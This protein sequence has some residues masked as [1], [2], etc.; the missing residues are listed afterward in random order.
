MASDSAATFGTGGI[1]TIGQQ[2]VRKLHRLNEN[3]LFSS[4]GA[5]GVSQLIADKLKSEWDKKTF[6]GIQSPDELMDKIGKTIV[7]L[8]GPYLQSATW[9]QPLGADT[10]SSLC[11]SLVAMP[12]ASTP[13]LF[14][15]DFNGA[16]ERATLQLPFIALGSGQPIADPFL[17]FLKRLLWVTTEPTVAEGKLAAVWTIDHVR[18]TTPGGVG[19]GIQ[20]GVLSGKAGKAPTVELLADGDIEEHLQKVSTTERAL[21][22]ELCGR[23]DTPPQL[24]S[25]EQQAQT[26][27]GTPATRKTD[28]KRSPPEEGVVGAGD[29]G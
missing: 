4:T 15:F 13:N 9:V 1:P 22:A 20:V 19:G 2:E 7:N 16:P 6:S 8:V 11:K 3:I 17:A 14:S 25:V 29:N 23:V 10:S 12:V 27:T 21:V 26:Q 5:V 28:S 24:P 18:H